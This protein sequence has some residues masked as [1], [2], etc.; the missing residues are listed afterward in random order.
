[1]ATN[2]SN[3]QLTEFGRLRVSGLTEQLPLNEMEKR[4]AAFLH[5]GNVCVL[6]T[7]L[8]DVPRATPIEYYSDNLTIYVAAS[9]GTKVPNIEG[10]QR[11]SIAIY[12]TPY[13]D[14]TDWHNV[15]GVQIMGEPELLRHDDQPD[16]YVAAL[17]IYDWRKYRKALGVAADEPRKTTI[18][19]I[20]P[21]KIEF[22]DL[23]LMREGY[24]VLQ[25]WKPEQ[26]QSGD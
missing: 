2:Q 3:P 8:N 1:M 9:R 14:W 24:S 21:V 6:A 22:R 10:N 18:I 20:K 15:T 13:T 4:I 17:Q 12:N 11:V 7:S 19:K 25:T 26:L 23:G 16:E 5:Q